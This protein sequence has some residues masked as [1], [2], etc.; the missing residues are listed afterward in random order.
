MKQHRLKQGLT[1]KPVS[2]VDWQQAKKW[3]KAPDPP[4]F[5]DYPA[6]YD[7]LAWTEAEFQ[8]RVQPG[9]YEVLGIV[10]ET[11]RLIGFVKAFDFNRDTCECGIEVFDP[12]DYG[13]G[14]A[15]EALGLFLAGL[16]QRPELRHVVGLIHP[17]NQRSLRLFA[18]LGFVHTG[19]WADPE[20]QE[21]VFERFS[22]I[23][24]R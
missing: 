14:Y 9:Q 20:V 4:E 16:K 23:L 24:N 17:D 5:E 6:P 12:Q 7:S 2:Y 22:Y 11:G 8:A 3:S 21:H 1:L 15:T 10:L 18:K 13:Q 19:Q